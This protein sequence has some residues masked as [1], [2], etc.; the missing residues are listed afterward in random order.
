VP[1]ET[2]NGSESRVILLAG[3]AIALGALAAYA[4]SFSGAMLY[5]DLA[6]ITDNPAI[7][8]LWPWT[9]APAGP[10]AGGLT[11]S[12][13]PFLQFTLA[14][15]YA[16]GGE[17]VWGY[18][19]ANLVI[20]LAAGLL[21]FGIARRTLVRAGSAQ[22]LAVAFA[23]A[24]LWTVHPLQTEA[25]SYIVQRAESLMGLCYLLTLYA[26]IRG[27]DGDAA[28][29]RWLGL[30]GLA[31][32][33]GMATKEVMVTA[34]LMVLLYDRTFVAGTFA[35]A[36]RRRGRYY[37]A[38][39][40]TWLPLAGFVAST[41]GNRGGTA[42]FGVAV[43]GWAYSMTQFQAVT[44]Y[45]RLA[46]WPNPLVFDYGTFWVR[47]PAEVLGYALP[48]L[49]L[50][51]LTIW[52]LARPAGNV[53][54]AGF[55]GAWFFGILA[56]SSLTPGTM[57]MI[58]EHRMYLPLA[59]VMAGVVLGLRLL[60]A[61]TGLP[62]PAQAALLVAAAGA[63]GALTFLRNETYASPVALWGDTVAKRP[64]NPVAV[65]NLGVALDRERQ[66]PAA[67]AQ[68]SRAA[69]LRPDLAAPRYDGGMALLQ[70]GRPAD[71]AALF[72][73]AVRLD[74]RAALPHEGLGLA[75]A[76]LGR[77]EEA[78]AHYEEA[79]RLQPGYARAHDNLGNAFLR[80]GRL[81]EAAVQYGEAVRLD[82]GSLVAHY[83]LANALARL[84]RPAEAAEQ[85]EA[86]LQLRP[87]DP[88]VEAALQRARQAAG[89]SS[90]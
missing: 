11:V 40:C 59:A 55:L 75:L 49:L 6:S 54:T 86:V 14:L 47:S 64:D 34:P 30:S 67:A 77:P 83:N 23:I 85:Y 53:R 52:A 33:L 41:G 25:V 39:A 61:K 35:E 5:D 90:P 16:L 17:R 65:Y 27:V 36:W 63:L 26:F 78:V 31:C 68:F 3:V 4:G 28:R 15:N 50:L 18:H 70:M 12:G 45:L 7:R 88:A 62:R 21:I 58:V 48:L 42:G 29:S 82:P 71:A 80:L 87:K 51:A 44:H 19:A 60:G 38:L 56:P 43:S 72:E 37:A 57:Q 20:H 89:A 66:F 24:L 69:Q 79:I 13:R 81:P 1:A 10:A 2:K 73:E 9:D 84:G 76:A 8:H 22:S 32:L 74:P 46:L